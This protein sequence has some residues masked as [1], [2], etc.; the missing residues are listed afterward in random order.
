MQFKKSKL[1]DD[2][3]TAYG[4]IDV[5]QALYLKFVK[6]LS[7]TEIGKLFDASASAVRQ[8]LRR[9][10]SLIDQPELNTIFEKNKTHFYGAAERLILT[11]LLQPEKLKSGSV[12]NLAYALRQVSDIATREKGRPLSGPEEL[13]ASMQSILEDVKATYKIQL[14]RITIEPV[15]IPKVE[16]DARALAIIDVKPDSV[17][18]IKGAEFSPTNNVNNLA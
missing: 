5:G 11:E 10:I 1:P 15:I 13:P 18:V 7:Y 17:K 6:D 12:N 3:Q 8:K 2:L 16:E 14:E 4:R 9:F